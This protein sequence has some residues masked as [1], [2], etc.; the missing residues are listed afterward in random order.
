VR[1]RSL[2]LVIANIFSLVMIVIVFLASARSFAA[3]QLLDVPAWL[4]AHIG[5]GEGQIA[6]PV[7]QRARA[8]YLQKV[9]EGAVKNRCYFAMDATRPNDLNDGQSGR[10]FYVICESERSFRAISAGHGS[11]RDLNG[12]ADF[13]NGRECAKNFGNALNSELTAGGAYV[14]AE[15]KPSFKGYYRVSAHQDAVLIRSFVQFDGEGETA[16]ARQRAIGGH[17]AVLLGGV[18]LRKDPGSPYANQDGYVPF[19]TLVDYAG[20]R[21]D[22]CTSWS[23]ADVPQILAMV[24]H[25]PTTLYIYPEAA[26]VNAVARAVAA[27]RSLS[28]EGLYWNAACLKEIRSPRFWPRETLEPILAAYRKD[29]PAPPPRPVPICKE[30]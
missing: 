24:K 9:S 28:R 27:G 7:L 26:D 3:E 4:R 2:L 8:L 19:G 25:D 21:S 29:H 16:N 13:A 18:C 6:Q 10:R 1:L 30:P 23:P 20:G 12:I 11:G 14:T 22:G 17:A 5:E 15:T